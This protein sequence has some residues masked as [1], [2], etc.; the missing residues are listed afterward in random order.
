MSILEQVREY[1]KLGI[2]IVPVIAGDKKPVTKHIGNFDSEGKPLYEWK[3]VS[4]TEEDYIKA[5]AGGIIHD[6]SNIIDVDFDDVAPK[7]AWIT[8]VP[9][10]VGLMTI[11]ALMT[12]TLKACERKD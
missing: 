4:W 12:N 3:N 6:Q 5:H 8:P 11:G 7:S 10:G 1:E 9:G 2:K